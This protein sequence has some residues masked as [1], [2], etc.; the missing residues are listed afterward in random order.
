MN[1]EKPLSPI[2]KLALLAKPRP[3]EWGDEP[4]RPTLK[5]I[6]FRVPIELVAKIDAF[7]AITNQSRNLTMISLLEAGVY[8]VVE[9]LEDTELYEIALE[10]NLNELTGN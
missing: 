1:D 5:M 7:A 8:A 4:D 3:T 6:S 2:E 10:H 9:Q